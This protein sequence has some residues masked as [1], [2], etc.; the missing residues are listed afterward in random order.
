MHI[1]KSIKYWSV[2]T[3][4]SILFISKQNMGVGCGLHENSPV[5]KQLLPSQCVRGP[6]TVTYL[7][8]VHGLL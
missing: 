5:Q 7:P 8:G 6:S 1:L 4:N 2:N 3:A